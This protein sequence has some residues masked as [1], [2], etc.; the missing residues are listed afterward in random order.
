MFVGIK[1]GLE[2]PLLSPSHPGSQGSRGESVCES[3]WR[4]APTLDPREGIVLE[5]Q[6]NEMRG[7]QPEEGRVLM[8]NMERGRG[9]QDGCLEGMHPGG[10]R[11]QETQFHLELRGPSWFPGRSPLLPRATGP[12]LP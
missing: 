10:G 1:S 9:A 12:H 2:L 5:G 7:L 4:T 3:Y 6:G 8:F 11:W